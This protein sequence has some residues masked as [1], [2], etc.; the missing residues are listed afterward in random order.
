MDFKIVLAFDSNYGIGN[1]TSGKYIPWKLSKDMKRFREITE[2]KNVNV[3]KKNA[4][5]MGRLTADTFR[6]PLK[7]RFNVV[8]TSKKDYRKDEGFESYDNFNTALKDM[9]NREVKNVFVIGGSKL[10]EKAINN[11]Y[12]KGA[13]ITF[14]QNSYNC[15][16][17]LSNDVIKKLDYCHVDNK[18]TH[19]EYD[20]NINKYINYDFI[21]LTYHNEEEIQYL[22][23]LEKIIN[24]GNYR[25][26]RNA[27]TYSL[28]G[29]RLVFDLDN[30]FPLLTTKKMFVRGIFEELLFFLRGDTDTKILEDK[31]VKIWHGN[32][33]KEF[34][35]ENNKDLQEYDMGPMYGFQW[36]H[37]NAPYKTSK[38]NYDNL[39]VDQLRDVIDKLVKDPHSRR[40]LLTTYNPAQSEQGVLYPCH[41]LTIQF[42]VEDSKRISLQMYQRSSDTF[43]GIP[44]NITSYATLLHII[45]NLVNNNKDRTHEEDYRPGRVIMILG[46]VHIYSDKEKG[47]HLDIVKKQISRR[48]NTYK[49]PKF[50]ITKKLETLEDLNKLE[51]S[52]MIV[53]DYVCN[54]GLKAKMV[55]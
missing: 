55:A 54:S 51:V 23:L 46:D 53:S 41:G 25:E 2:G 43:L 52:D 48:D 7:N 34:I 44:F 33:T 21:D 38:D 17:R 40:I 36:R 16:I 50:E 29:E 37:F 35:E 5:I 30:G 14:I 9:K 42:Y 39:G 10:V 45:V 31:N 47:D 19:R 18:N 12:F 4:I 13:Y 24:N 15:E 20:M 3:D 26:T 27:K 8:I 22:N 1:N 49:F 32:T 6:K 28:F 11:T